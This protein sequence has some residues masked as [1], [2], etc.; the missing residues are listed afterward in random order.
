MK[1]DASLLISS[2]S[3]IVAIIVISNGAGATGSN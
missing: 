2:N 3:V 1:Y